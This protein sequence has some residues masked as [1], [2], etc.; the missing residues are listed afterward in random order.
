MC[1]LFLYR[2]KSLFK[3]AS[4]LFAKYTL[5]GGVGRQRPNRGEESYMTPLWVSRT[6]AGRGINIRNASPRI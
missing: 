2:T 1:N 6:D 4:T 3:K 5:G